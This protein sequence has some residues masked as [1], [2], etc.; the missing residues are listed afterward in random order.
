MMTNTA[1]QSILLLDLHIFFFDSS[2]R[3]GKAA[4]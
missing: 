4:L 3:I 2:F 1:H